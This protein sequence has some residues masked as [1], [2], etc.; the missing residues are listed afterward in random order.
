[1]PTKRTKPIERPFQEMGEYVRAALKARGWTQKEL[2]RTLRV[3]PWTVNE[4]LRGKK[5]PSAIRVGEIAALLRLDPDRLA[6]LSGQEV[7][8]VMP[9]Y[10]WNRVPWN[11][12][13]E[14]IEFMHRSI[15]AARALL[16]LGA[17]YK[18]FELLNNGSIRFLASL[19][20]KERVHPGVNSRPS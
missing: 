18:G 19:V 10:E 20:E 5:R 8:E 2:A 16:D 15:D 17:P 13:Q 9:G 6:E 1:M 3:R 14:F 7:T 4:Y 12:T 11:T